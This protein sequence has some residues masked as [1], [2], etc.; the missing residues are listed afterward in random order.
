MGVMSCLPVLAL[1]IPEH[2]ERVTDQ[3]D[4]ISDEQEVAL[5]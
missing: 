2:D 3:A 4:M 1:T 5:E